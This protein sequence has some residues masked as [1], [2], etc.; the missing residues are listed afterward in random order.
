M[1]APGRRRCLRRLPRPFAH[2]HTYGSG[3]LLSCVSSLR[4]SGEVEAFGRRR[5]DPRRAVGGVEVAV[6]APVIEAPVVERD[7]EPHVRSIGRQ[8][9]LVNLVY[10]SLTSLVWFPTHLLWMPSPLA[11]VGPGR[12]RS[13][14]DGRCV[15]PGW[16]INI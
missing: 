10:N 4:R 2:G 9:P 7:P 11:T 13:V 1:P 3:F 8:V 12:H 5:C 15:A 14:S 16:A 6:V